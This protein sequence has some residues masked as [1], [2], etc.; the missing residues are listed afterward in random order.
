[1]K[2]PVQPRYL[3]REALYRKRIEAGLSQAELAE[4]CGTIQSQVSNWERGNSGCNIGMLHKLAKALDE[5]LRSIGQPGCG[6]LDLMLD[7][8]KTKAAA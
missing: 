3:S 6:P 1:M 8:S 2:K 7:R 4:R 5:Q